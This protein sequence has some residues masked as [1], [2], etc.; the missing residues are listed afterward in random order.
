LAKDQAIIR[1]PKNQNTRCHSERR[2]F[3]RGEGISVFSTAVREHSSVWRPAAQTAEITLK[4]QNSIDTSFIV[5]QYLVLEGPA[6]L[7]IGLVFQATGPAVQISQ[8]KTFNGGSFM[9]T[10]KKAKKKK[11]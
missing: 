1:N 5:P 11:H 9:A 2:V 6:V 3:F 8:G 7:S 4:L 10:K